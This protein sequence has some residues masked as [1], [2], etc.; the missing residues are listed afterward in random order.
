MYFEATNKVRNPYGKFYAV[1]IYKKETLLK[2]ISHCINYPLLGEKSESLKK[3]NQKLSFLVSV[4]LSCHHEKF[5]TFFG[6]I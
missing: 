3:L 6:K 5:H 1:E 2:I 4:V